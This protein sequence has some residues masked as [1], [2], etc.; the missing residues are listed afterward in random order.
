MQQILLNLLNNAIKF[1]DNDSRII[2]TA[3]A[4]HSTVDE[5]KSF[6]ELKVKDFGLGIT[7]QDL[8][9]IFERYYKT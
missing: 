6:L 4:T 8:P 1:S 3:K 9:N 7:A 2:I 5:N